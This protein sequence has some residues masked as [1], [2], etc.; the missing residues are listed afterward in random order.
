MNTHICQPHFFFYSQLVSSALAEDL[1]HGDI[2]TDSIVSADTFGSAVIVAK[3]P[4]VLAGT[5]I[6]Q[7]AFR[8]IDPDI[9]FKDVKKE[10]S[11]VYQGDVV[12]SLYGRL[13][14]ILKAERVALNFIQRM[15][16][17]ATLTRSFVKELS[18]LSCKLVDT[19]KTTP[20]MR[21]LQKYA[22]RIGGGHNH[23]YGL[24][25]GILIKDNHILACGSIK[26]SINMARAN[27]P[28]TLLIEI[29]VT[30]IEELEDAIKAGADAVLLDNMDLMTL[31]GA[32]ALARKLNPRLILEASGGINL[33]N[34]REI[35]ET[36]VDIVS[37]G[38]LTHSAKASDLSLRILK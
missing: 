3:E 15:C 12:M 30:D 5:F 22:V 14:A 27:I 28:H 34:V 37:V 7:E 29:E 38:L 23:R 21:L 33:K 11:E 9:Y 4:A 20:G 10:G 36:G 17:I 32:V 6:A 31:R 25:D 19:R 2:T 8:Q 35:A 26:K 1:E 18:G 16:G 24:S 13:A